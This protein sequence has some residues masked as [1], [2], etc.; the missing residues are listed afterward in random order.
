MPLPISISIGV[1]PAIEITSCFE[2]PTTPLGYNELS[3]AGALYCHP[4]GGGKYM[5]VMHIRKTSASDEGRQRHS[6]HA[7]LL[8]PSGFRSGL[9][10]SYCGKSAGLVRY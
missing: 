5:A 2:P 8:F 10:G 1:D 7:Q 9:Y 4:S 6:A 3:I